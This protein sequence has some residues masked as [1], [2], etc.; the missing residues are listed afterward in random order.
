M[1]SAICFNLDQSKNLLSG[2]E[3]EKVN[4]KFWSQNPQNLK[5]QG[6]H[7]IPVNRVFVRK[8]LLE[9][10]D[11]Y[12]GCCNITVVMLKLT[13][14]NHAITPIES[15][16]LCV[17][18]SVDTSLYSLLLQTVLNQFDWDFTGVFIMSQH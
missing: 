4:N 7:G 2:N 13:L 16:W 8:K 17:Q 3:L 1:T 9:T 11:R 10:M 18:L 14:K 15:G 12:T 6:A 5:K